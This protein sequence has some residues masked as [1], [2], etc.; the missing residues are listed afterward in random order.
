MRP[1]PNV[2]IDAALDHGD[3]EKLRNSDE[4]DDHSEARL[5]VEHVT[6]H[7]EQRAACTIGVEMQSPTNFPTASA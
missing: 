1:F 4:Q 3:D 7:A 5:G 6:Q 2:N